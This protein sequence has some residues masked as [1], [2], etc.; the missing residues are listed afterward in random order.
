MMLRYR[1]NVGI[2]L[3][4][5]KGQVLIGR[6]QS[7]GPEIVEP[8]YEWQ[9]PQGGIDEGEDLEAAARREL[10]EE[11]NITS[12]SFLRA[13]PGWW[14]YD[15]PPYD[16]SPHKLSPF[17]GQKQRWV[18]FRFDGTDDEIDVVHPPTG[19]PQEF[20]E[21]RWDWLHCLPGLVTPHKRPVYLLMA[22]AFAPFA[23]SSAKEHIL[24]G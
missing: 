3:F 24:R 15:F 7:S 18:A 20:F 16:G 1:P 5:K 10:W 4:N 13:S 17:A 6:A 14:T 9:C 12:V 2:A 11:T 21:W 22:E 19:E 23:A 8:G